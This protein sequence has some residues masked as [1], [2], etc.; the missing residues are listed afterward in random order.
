MN[1]CGGEDSGVLRNLDKLSRISSFG[2]DGTSSYVSRRHHPLKPCL[3]LT[4]HHH[5]PS[6]FLSHQYCHHH[7][8]C[9]P[10]DPP[11]SPT[12]LSSPPEPFNYPTSPPCIDLKQMTSLP[13]LPKKK[14][15]VSKLVSPFE[16]KKKSAGTA[17][18]LS[19]I[20]WNRMVVSLTWLST[21][22]QRKILRQLP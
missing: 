6:L 3:F 8:S 4:H 14:F 2:L 18:F 22:S 1:G 12:P 13:M 15:S 16:P 10:L 19:E 17:K 11:S 9:P 5:L 21:R 20:A 7:R